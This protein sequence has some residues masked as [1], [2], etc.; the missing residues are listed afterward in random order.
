MPQ[1]PLPDFPNAKPFVKW[2][3]GKRSLLPELL[4]R[5]P[6]EFNNYYEPFVG[7]GAL[8]FALRN[9]RRINLG[10]GGAGILK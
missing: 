5:V 10:G 1:P 2:V 4:E 9:E 3:G 7:G 6:P 8:F